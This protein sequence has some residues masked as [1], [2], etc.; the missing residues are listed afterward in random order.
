M[1]PDKDETSKD[2]VAAIPEL[3]DICALREVEVPDELKR[4]LWEQ[5]SPRRRRSLPML[6][7]QVPFCWKKLSQIS[8]VAVSKFG[9]K[10]G[11]VTM[12]ARL[13]LLLMTFALW[14]ES[15]WLPTTIMTTAQWQKVTRRQDASRGRPCMKLW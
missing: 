12:T 6:P 10:F 1:P 13:P 4:G 5:R 3:L 11:R 14:M 9:R 15:T 8:Q 2:I 7:F